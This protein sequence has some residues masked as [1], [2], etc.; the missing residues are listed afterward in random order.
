MIKP[1]NFDKEKKYPVVMFQYGGPGNQQ[2]VNSWNIGSMGNG[3]LFD[4][5]LAQKGFIIVA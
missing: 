4:Y 2:V 1:S 3:G 5:Y